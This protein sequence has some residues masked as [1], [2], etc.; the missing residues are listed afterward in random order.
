MTMKN[1]LFPLFLFALLLSSCSTKQERYVVIVSL[2]GFRWDYCKMYNTPFLDSIAMVGVSGRMRPSYPSKTFPNHYTIATGLVPDHHGIIANRFI[3]RV[4]GRQ[5]SLSTPETKYDAYFYHGEPIWVTSQLQGI[6]AATVYWPGSDVPIKD[7][8]PSVYHKYSDSLLRHEERIQEVVRL[9]SLPESERPHLV[10]CYFEEPDHTGH[11]F[12]PQ[13]QETSDMI[14]H[15]DSLMCQFYCELSKLEIFDDVNFIVTSDHGMTSVSSERMIRLSDY[16][17]PEWIENVDYSIPTMLDAVSEDR[18]GVMVNYADS[19]IDRL[20][21]V[22]HIYVW[23]RDE[24]PDSL[25]FGS[26]ANIGEIIIDSEPGWLVDEKETLYKGAH[27]FNPFH[28]DMQVPF[29][30]IGPQFKQSYHKS[31]IFQNTAIYP[32][33]CRLLNIEPAPVDGHIEEV[34][35]FLR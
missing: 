26:N 3:D 5:F 20:K 34:E 10:M 21:N 12:D 33:L 23:R 9:L 28:L 14:E 1:L 15:L 8:Y 25:Q 17:S 13:S 24:V 18:D 27:G 19:I 6:K 31:D 22:P 2:D 16:L 4:S 30:A 29:F 7:I 35:D 32:L 11:M